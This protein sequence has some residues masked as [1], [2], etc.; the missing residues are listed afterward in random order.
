MQADEIKER[1]EQIAETG[2]GKTLAAY[3]AAVAVLLALAI[4]GGSN[5]TEDK[6]NENIHASDTWAFYQAKTVRQAQLRLAVDALDLELQAHPDL[7]APVQNA[8]RA[9][10]D[11]YESEPET[12]EGKTELLAQ[13]KE[14]EAVRDRADRQGSWFDGAEAALQLAI[15]LASVTAIINGLALLL[16]SGVLAAA[17]AVAT[18]N[19]YFLV[20]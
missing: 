11:R 2:S 17:G 20:L 4:L 14:H 18:A 16:V 9:T 5:A 10:I 6:A 12:G 8:Y 13:A 19:G 15:V 7:P 3:I 1:L